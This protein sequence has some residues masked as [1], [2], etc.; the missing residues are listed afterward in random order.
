MKHLK[1]L[2]PF[3]LA[4]ALYGAKGKLWVP[5]RCI[6]RID[7]TDAKCKDISA[8]VMGCSNV[9]VTHQCVSVKPL[10]DTAQGLHCKAD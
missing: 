6:T 3:I 2:L 7:L 5:L 4:T 1:W 8:D 9:L 10:E